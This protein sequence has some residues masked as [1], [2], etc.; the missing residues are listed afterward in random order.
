M[1]IFDSDSKCDVVEK[2]TDLCSQANLCLSSC[3]AWLALPSH[4]F[5]A[6]FIYETETNAWLK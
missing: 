4:L 2:S 1:N 3:T 6:F 5:I